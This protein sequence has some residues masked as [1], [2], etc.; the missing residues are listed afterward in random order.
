MR[1]PFWK[2]TQWT[3]W[4]CVGLSGCLHG[5]DWRAAVSKPLMRPVADRRESLPQPK[6]IGPRRDHRTSFVPP[7][8]SPVPAV[9]VSPSTRTPMPIVSGPRAVSSKLGVPTANH[10]T[11]SAI[12]TRPTAL[13]ASGM[14]SVSH[15]TAAAVQ[16]PTTKDE[17]QPRG[18]KIHEAAFI[19][20]PV[21][22]A[23]PL[24]ADLPQ[25]SVPA[26]G[27]RGGVS[28]P[29]DSQETGGLTPPRSPEHLMDDRAKNQAHPSREVF[30]EFERT[31]PLRKPSV[32]QE[33]AATTEDDEV[34]VAPKREPIAPRPLPMIIPAGTSAPVIEP[35]VPRSFPPVSAKELPDV[36]DIITTAPDSPDP[37]LEQVARPRD[38]A[39][40]VEQVFEDLRQRRL[41]QA[42]QRTAWL[43]QIVTRRESALEETSPVKLS[44]DA[45]EPRRL[46]VDEHAAPVNTTPSE[47]S[48]DD[49]EITN[50]P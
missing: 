40:L 44:S 43:K 5:Q 3:S 21:P 16:P 26:T 36:T 24:M 23:V 22:P 34:V 6:V 49:N 50:R 48:L 29:L 19:P 13:T 28:P 32:T 11:P 31:I 39:V 37:N 12:V 7:A 25:K 1:H 15:S 27:E 30:A 42:R 47:K 41:D 18:A 17:A 38:V 20:P 35:G 14:G 33:P 46:H 8:N 9:V 10:A 2:W 4:L 45:S